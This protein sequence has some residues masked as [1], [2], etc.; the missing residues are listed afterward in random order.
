MSSVYLFR[1]RYEYWTFPIQV[2]TLWISSKP[3]KEFD[4]PMTGFQEV[5]FWYERTKYPPVIGGGDL[6]VLF[7]KIH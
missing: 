6:L 4:M 5:L 3:N 2:V 7:R 1:N